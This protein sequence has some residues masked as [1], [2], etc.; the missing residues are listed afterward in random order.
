VIA[1]SKGREVTVQVDIGE[2]E[3]QSVKMAAPRAIKRQRSLVD[4]LD[5]I[6]NCL[7]K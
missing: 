3:S 7:T 5:Q 4:V 1:A 2:G 6:R